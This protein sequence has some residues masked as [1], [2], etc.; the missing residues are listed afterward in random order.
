M[1]VWDAARALAME[2]ISATLRVKAREVSLTRVMTSL[3]TDGRIPFDDLGQYDFEKGLEPAVAQNLSRL[4][5]AHRHGLDA[6]SV[7]FSKIGGIV[8]YKSNEGGPQPVA[9]A[10]L[11]SEQIIGAEIHHHELQ[12]QGRASHDGYIY[13]D[14]GLKQPVFGHTPKGHQKAQWKGKY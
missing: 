1:L 12:H 8:D 7:D 13:L 14:N 5:L 9:A 3:V 4:V 10:H 2:N 6:A 11:D